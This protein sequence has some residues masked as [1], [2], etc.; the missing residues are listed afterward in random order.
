M[1][2]SFRGRV[3]QI[4]GE[5]VQVWDVRSGH[6]VFLQRTRIQGGDDLRLNDELLVEGDEGR[7]RARRLS[8]A[9]ET[10]RLAEI[11]AD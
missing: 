10:P 1:S 7:R 11:A 3:S 9:V 4:A 5:L 2:T 6:S 8:G